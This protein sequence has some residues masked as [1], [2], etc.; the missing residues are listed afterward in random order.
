[1]HPRHPAA[2]QRVMWVDICVGEQ[3]VGG[4][5]D[6]TGLIQTVEKGRVFNGSYHCTCY[7]SRPAQILTQTNFYTA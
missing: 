3:L 2:L 1:M 4:G 5:P 6:T 7:Q